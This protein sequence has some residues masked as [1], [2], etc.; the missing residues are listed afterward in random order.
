MAVSYV[1]RVLPSILPRFVL[2]S[3]LL[4]SH[5]FNM[6]VKDCYLLLGVD[7]S[8][9]VVDV[10]EAYLRLAKLYHPDCGRSTADAAKFSEIEQAYRVVMDH[11]TTLEMA[12]PEVIKEDFDKERFEINHTAPQH[13]QY[14]EYEGIGTGS[15]SK[16]QKQYEQYRVQRASDKLVDY[17]TMRFGDQET[18]IAEPEKRAIRRSKQSKVIDRLVEDLI[19][20]AM[21]KGEFKNLSGSGKPLKLEQELFV[22]STTRRLNKVLID[23]GFAPEWISLDK[24][25]RQDIYH[26]RESLLIARKKLGPSPLAMQA[27]NQWNHILREFENKL[28]F[29]NK[30][31]DKFNMIVPILNKQKVHVNFDRE[32]TRALEDYGYGMVDDIE[33]H[34]HSTADQNKSS[35]KN[36]VI[37]YFLKLFERY[38]EMFGG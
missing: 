33:I 14:L 19:Q 1:L 23:S 35:H 2:L 9:T 22:D 20:E 7:W 36:V 34:M 17:K 21:S 16:R 27:D 32:V 10:R 5:S 4:C 26:L 30:K 29:V 37:S 6:N 8:A 24:E 15:P 13:R 38:K 18:S 3:R 25:I 31:I 28:C 11:V 12:G